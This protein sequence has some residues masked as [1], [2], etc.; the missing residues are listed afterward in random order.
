[1]RNNCAPHCLKMMAPLNGRTGRV[2]VRR[3]HN[4][5]SQDTN[6]APVDTIRHKRHHRSPGPLAD[7]EPPMDPGF[8]GGVGA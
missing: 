3:R 1:M 4:G 8:G 6:S 2:G 7:P 5:T